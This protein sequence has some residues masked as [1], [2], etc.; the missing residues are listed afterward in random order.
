[1]LLQVLKVNMCCC[2]QATELGCHWPAIG[3]QVVLHPM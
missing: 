1:L 2:V 3:G